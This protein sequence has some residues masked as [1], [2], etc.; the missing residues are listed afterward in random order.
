MVRFPT[1]HIPWIEF[2]PYGWKSYYPVRFQT[3]NVHSIYHGKISTHS[4]HRDIFNQSSFRE[5]VELQFG[6]ESNGPRTLPT[7]IYVVSKKI[8]SQDDTQ[9]Q[10][11]P[12]G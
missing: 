2:Q 4:M 1:T 6:D 8:G 11:F 10:I 7:F 12:L 9:N 3:P 5:G